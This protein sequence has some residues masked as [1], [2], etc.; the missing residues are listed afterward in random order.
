MN[1]HWLG[2]VAATRCAY[3]NKRVN[4]HLIQ[5]G[6][7]YELRTEKKRPWSIDSQ[8]VYWSMGAAA[9][10]EASSAA[11]VR[12]WTA[13]I[14]CMLKFWEIRSKKSIMNIYNGAPCRRAS[15]NPTFVGQIVVHQIQR[16]SS[17]CPDAT[18]SRSIAY[19]GQRS[20]YHLSGLL[21]SQTIHRWASV[22]SCIWRFPH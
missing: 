14:G 9:T 15:S 3:Y 6:N 17:S 4:I 2:R 22:P 19:S 8:R 12:W 1:D 18:T 21:A 7:I 16:R 11:L 5:K 10:A 20:D 13:Q